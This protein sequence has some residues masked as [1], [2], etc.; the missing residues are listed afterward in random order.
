MHN[1]KS[2]YGY[3]NAQNIS[4]QFCLSNREDVLI[5]SSQIWLMKT[6]EVILVILS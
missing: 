3:E 5:I 1:S 2:V 6:G 4:V